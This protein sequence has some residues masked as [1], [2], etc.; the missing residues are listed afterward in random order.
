[1]V[2]VTRVGEVTVF[3]FHIQN[4]LIIQIMWTNKDP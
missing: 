2:D 1:M 4:I 3:M